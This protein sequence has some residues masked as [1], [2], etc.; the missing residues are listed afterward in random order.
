M[1]IY[2]FLT[3]L[4]IKCRCEQKSEVYVQNIIYRIKQV[5]RTQCRGK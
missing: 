2:D 4:E 3:E 1:Q 5:F